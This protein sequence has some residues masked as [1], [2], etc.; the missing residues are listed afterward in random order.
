MIKI[1]TAYSSFSA[2]IIQEE[3]GEDAMS[4]FNTEKR[5]LL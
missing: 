2:K 5:M 1:Y 3:E 4:F